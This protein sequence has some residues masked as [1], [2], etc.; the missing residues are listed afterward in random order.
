MVCFSKGMIN[1][2]DKHGNK[3]WVKR[4]DPRYISGELLLNKNI[5]HKTND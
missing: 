1:V 2:I 3:L 5:K 4:D